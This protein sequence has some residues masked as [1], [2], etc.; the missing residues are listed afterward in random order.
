LRVRAHTHTH[1]SVT[2]GAH[3]LHR[4]RSQPERLH[5]G[6]CELIEMQDMK[7]SCLNDGALQAST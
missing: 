4:H 5:E 2:T 6:G 1:A 7:T 3:R